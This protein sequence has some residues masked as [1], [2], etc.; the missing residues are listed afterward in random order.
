MPK[1]RTLEAAWG[2]RAAAAATDQYD[3]DSESDE[4]FR[5]AALSLD[6]PPPSCSTTC[7]GFDPAAGER[8]VYPTNFPVRDY[9]LSV[10]R[11]A[12]F[13]N[14]LVCLP[15]G[16]GKT[17]VAAVVMY[18]FYRWYPNGKVVFLAPT[19]PLVS[20]QIEACHNITGIPQTHVAEMTGRSTYIRIRPLFTECCGH[21][22]CVCVC[23]CAGSLPPSQRAGLWHCKRVFFLTPQVMHN[24][25]AR[26]V[27]PAQQVRCVV[28]DEAH[29]ALG[30]HAY[31]Q[32]Q[33]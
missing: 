7:P 8:W 15:T 6:A 20:Q 11:R 33:L 29:K 3:F 12:L 31:C 13:V 26:G 25:L 18:N 24:D 17:F 30:N 28:F 27:C 23:V 19:K 22:V 10:T 14:T 4:L 5:T 16:L 2:T 9:Q 1:Q 32:V 21:A